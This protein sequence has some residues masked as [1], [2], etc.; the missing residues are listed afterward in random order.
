MNCVIYGTACTYASTPSSSTPVSGR[1]KGHDGKSPALGSSSPD[2]K[3]VHLA[4]SGSLMDLDVQDSPSSSSYQEEMFLGPG[5]SSTG[6]QNLL[7]RLSMARSMVIGAFL[8]P[9][10]TSLAQ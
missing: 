2:K 9:S 5:S 10:V 6:A 8:L 3:D 4:R 1:K 7:T